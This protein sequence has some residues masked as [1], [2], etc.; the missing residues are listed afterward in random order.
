MDKSQ[1][2]LS[3]V[4][5]PY[6]SRGYSFGGCDCWGLVYLYYKEVMGF[7][8]RLSDEYLNHDD[9]ST[10]M[11]AQIDEWEKVERPTEHDLV[12]VCF[13]GEIPLHCGVMISPTKILH[14][15]TE[16]SQVQIWS[17][18]SMLRHLRRYYKMNTEPR[19]EFYRCRR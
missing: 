12:F 17:L 5:A 6:K 9:F 13:N 14:A 3:I 19:V 15:Y 8:P 4:G 7:T 11:M 16:G 2:I 18:F 1:F 10:A